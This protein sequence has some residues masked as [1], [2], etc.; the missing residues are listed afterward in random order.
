[1]EFADG[2]VLVRV[3]LFSPQIEPR[4]IVIFLAC[5]PGG[6]VDGGESMGQGPR[7]HGLQL[8]LH[9]HSRIVAQVS[10]GLLTLFQ[11]PGCTQS[12]GLEVGP[13]EGQL[14]EAACIPR[15]MTPSLNHSN[16]LLLSSYLLLHPLTSLPP[17]YKHLAI[18]LDSPG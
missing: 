14:W 17:S 1:M 12:L 11:L 7:R 8:L 18:T 3:I 10:Q 2:K 4:S 6:I 16:L 9:R 5:R 13:G 15:F